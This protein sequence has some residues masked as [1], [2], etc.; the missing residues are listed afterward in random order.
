[1]RVLVVAMSLLGWVTAADPVLAEPH[2]DAAAAEKLF[3]RGR[4]AA[5]RGDWQRAC[6]DFAASQRLDPGAGTLLN[7]AMCELAQQKL[8]SAWLHFNE[9]AQLLE[10][11][12][13]RFPFIR[14]QLQKLSPRVPRLTLS[15]SPDMPAGAQVWRANSELGVSSLGVALP[16]DPGSVELSVTCAGRET[17]RISVTLREAEQ[18]QVTLEPGAPLRGNTAPLTFGAAR[19]THPGG[20]QKSLG[21][22]L[23][24]VGS[25]G[26]GLGLASG[27]V[28]A[29]R[30]RTAEAH[31]PANR[32]DASGFRAVESGERWL[33]VN[34]VSWSVG[35]AAVVSG[36]VLLVLSH[37][38][39]RDAA[40]QALPGGAAFV[41]G[42][43]Y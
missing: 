29:E 23:V 18:L 42:G 35:A 2:V 3:E 40:I 10:P 11:G 34:T 4:S 30:Q 26:L 19:S 22:S 27:L 21:L 1:M 5:R 9:A 25:V 37:D 8:A 14:A 38:E 24:A 17:R 13:D 41:Y 32:C 33:A 43:R 39:Q 12:D 31:C 16:V 7:W 6:E 36:A 20:V 15:L 28:V